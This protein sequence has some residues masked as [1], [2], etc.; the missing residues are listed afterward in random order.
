MKLTAI[1]PSTS[2]PRAAF[3][4]DHEIVPHEHACVGVG[5]GRAIVHI[6]NSDSPCD[7]VISILELPQAR[8]FVHFGA[9]PIERIPLFR[10]WTIQRNR[11][12]RT[13]GI[14]FSIP[15]SVGR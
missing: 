2:I 5:W 14:F 15:N 12:W 7:V 6:R 4:T 11:R 1:Y 9:I 8:L 3:K 13:I 10:G